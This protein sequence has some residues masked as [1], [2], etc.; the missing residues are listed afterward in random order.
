[1]SGPIA[2]GALGGTIA[3]TPRAGDGGIVPT[4]GAED[5]VSSVASELGIEARAE[6]IRSV[7][8]ASI[9]VDD[10]REALAWANAQVDDGCAG[11]VISQGT[12]TL[13]ETSWLLD[14]LWKRDEPLV[15]IGAMRGPAAPG[16]D[17][18]GNVAGA[19]VVASDPQAR[20]R[21][22]LVTLADQIHAARWVVKAHTSSVAAFTSPAAG[23][24]GLVAEKAAHWFA[25]AGERPSLEL[26]L[27]TEGDG[28]WVPLIQTHLMDRGELVRAAVEAGAKGLV[29]AA[30]G[31]GHVSEDVADALEEAARSIPVVL[32]S[33]TNAGTVHRNTYGFK[34]AEMDLIQRG[35][36]PSGW[37][38]PLKARLLLFLVLANGGS[39]ETVM[40]A[41]EAL[42]PSLPGTPTK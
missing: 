24:V 21:G 11:I 22:V 14:L 37:L 27:P 2:F 20:G 3:M 10:I 33:R 29:V 16:A 18:P 15:V 40:H 30:T 41:F 23:P 31:V 28:P 35:L 4:L 1:M 12:D 9:G 8:S 13:E 39:R 34:G 32:A 42:G 38:N 6:T 19:L 36:V 25:P 17:G 5:L 26:S 7:G